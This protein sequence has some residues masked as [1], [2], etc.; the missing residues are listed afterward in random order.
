MDSTGLRDPEPTTIEFRCLG[1]FAFRVPDGA[2]QNAPS[3]AAGG[4][5]LRYMANHTNASIACQSLAEA[6]W[7]ELDAAQSAHRLHI[8]ASGAR[9][10]LRSLTRDVNPIVYSHS[11]YGWSSRLRILRDIDVLERCFRGGSP[12]AYLRGIRTYAGAFL[13]GDN[14]DWVVPLRVL[15][16][17]M[18]ATMLEALATSAL[19]AHDYPRANCFALELIAVDRAHER[20]TQL[21]MVSFARTGRRA[22]ALIEYDHLEIY[23][24]KW[25]NVAPTSE[26]TRLRTSIANGGPY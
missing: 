8:A 15:Y 21:A 14:A 17:H 2:W 5:F 25:L 20:A 4:Q 22:Q 3:G 10:A 7:P 26:T 13:S 23:L 12:D 19:E 18:Y 24:R 6:L 9:T 11:T 1:L 16:E